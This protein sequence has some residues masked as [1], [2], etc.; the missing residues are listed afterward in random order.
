MT[1]LYMLN[2]HDAYYFQ[3]GAELDPRLGA[4]TGPIVVPQSASDS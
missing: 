3:R 4:G 2:D 1:E